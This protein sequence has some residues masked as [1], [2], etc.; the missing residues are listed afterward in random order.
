MTGKYT[1]KES[2]EVTIS[3]TYA[4]LSVRDLIWLTLQEIKCIKH[5]NKGMNNA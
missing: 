3:S 2:F 4:S 1:V 5:L